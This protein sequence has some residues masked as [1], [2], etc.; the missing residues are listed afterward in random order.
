MTWTAGLYYADQNRRFLDD[1]YITGLQ[2]SFQSIYGY[3]VGS[4]ASIS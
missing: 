4:T 2:S 1:E 3:P